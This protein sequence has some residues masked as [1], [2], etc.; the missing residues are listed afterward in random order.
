MCYSI[1][2]NGW[3]LLIY[4]FFSQLK[5]KAEHW[6]VTRSEL[7]VIFVTCTTAYSPRINIPGFICQC[8]VDECGMCIEAETLCAMLGSDAK[9][10]VLIG[11]H[12][13]LQPIIKCEKA[14]DLGLGISMFERYSVRAHLL[15]IQYRMVSNHK[16]VSYLDVLY[17][18][19]WQGFVVLLSASPT[20][21][22]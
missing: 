20:S 17:P 13:Q 2:I 3:C 15:E 9:Q 1:A 10:V 8:I 7:D 18:S 22:N 12:K 4:S 16:T 19:G 21:E 5:S 14:K 11:D 6:A